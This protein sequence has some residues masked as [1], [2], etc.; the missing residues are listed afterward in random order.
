LDAT[1]INVGWVY[2]DPALAR[3]R[4]AATGK[5]LLLYWTAA[6]CPPCQEMRVTVL[7]TPEFARE[8][9]EW[10]LAELSGDAPDAQVW[11]ERLGLSTY[12]TM[13]VLSPAGD[14]AVRLP[15]GLTGS[16]FCEVMRAAR[17]AKRNIAALAAAIARGNTVLSEPELTL[18][19]YHSWRQDART[20][21]SSERTSF[22]Q[23]LMAIARP[24]RRDEWARIVTQRVIEES[25]A[26]EAKESAAAHAELC[27]QFLGVL[28]GPAATYANLY[29][30][31]VDP[32][33]AVTFL[34]AKGG[35]D[36]AFL[37]AAWSVSIEAMLVEETLSGTERLI[38][39]AALVGL[40]KARTGSDEV[41]ADLRQRCVHLVHE[42]D[43]ATN[44]IPERQS[45]M[46]MAGHLLRFI[47]LPQES[48]RV[49]EREL[50]KSADP[51]YFMP[52]LADLARER[53]D[54]AESM[55]WM[56]RARDEA[57]GPATRFALSARYVSSLRTATP[58]DH[59]R[60]AKATLQALQELQ[61]RHTL[62]YG[63]FRRTLNTLVNELTGWAGAERPAG[64]AA[65][66]AAG[67]ATERKA[68]LARVKAT[69]AQ[70]AAAEP[71]SESRGELEAA[72][73]SLKV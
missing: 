5:P 51:Y 37:T 35:V 55:N 17:N 22:F 72:A 16:R 70:M 60:V 42:L 9:R 33:P 68:I 2:N 71:D 38:A 49:F 19:A 13:L 1:E 24:G 7:R 34:T 31:N 25:A 23:K 26:A 61:G 6:W 47:G 44:D 43:R 10:V 73:Q 32:R 11:G 3:E 36:R 48:F 56:Q 64:S 58:Q 69:L 30:L 54:V 57:P 4:S 12:P 63:V 29:Y 41:S 40:S 18:L 66:P 45:V 59:E 28:S 65:A 52:Y 8:S 39:H 46:N 21:S 62:F 67:N 27:G 20:L 50:Q 14:E 15:G 53:G